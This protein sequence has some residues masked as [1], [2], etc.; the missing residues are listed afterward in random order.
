[1]SGRD[2]TSDSAAAYALLILLGALAGLV[3]FIAG[4]VHSWRSR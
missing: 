2:R 3:A 4:A 1:M